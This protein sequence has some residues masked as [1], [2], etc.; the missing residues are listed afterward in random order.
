MGDPGEPPSFFPLSTDGF[1]GD[2]WLLPRPVVLCCLCLLPC[3]SGWGDDDS[4]VVVDAGFEA[5]SGTFSTLQAF[6][7]ATYLLIPWEEEEEEEDSLCFLPFFFFQAPSFRWLKNLLKHQRDAVCFGTLDVH[8]DFPAEFLKGKEEVCACGGTEGKAQHC[9][10][11]PDAKEDVWDWT[12]DHERACHS[13]KDPRFANSL[14]AF[15]QR[16]HGGGMCFGFIPFGH[17][18]QSILPLRRRPR[19][20]MQWSCTPLPVP[21]ASPENNI[22]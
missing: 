12:V 20:L 9:E 6:S 8:R 7:S 16:A 2:S 19:L 1:T 14:I 21:Y 5:G 18:L 10:P 22:S 11:Q 3:G 15:F 13:I 4:T 17:F